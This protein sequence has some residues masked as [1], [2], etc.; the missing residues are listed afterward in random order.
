MILQ[1][2]DDMRG[3]LNNL[4][5]LQKCSSSENSAM[6]TY[7]THDAMFIYYLFQILITN[8]TK[9]ALSAL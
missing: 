3:Q 1:Q 2:L 8:S 6:H 7:E 9:V 4:I 5:I